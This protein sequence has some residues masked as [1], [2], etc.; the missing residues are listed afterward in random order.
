MIH[1]A[2]IIENCVSLGD[3]VTVEPGAVI[4]VK[5]AIRNL[6]HFTGSVEIGRH[7]KIGANVVVAIGEGITKIGENCIIMN[8]ANIGHDV[9]IGNNVEIGAGVI[10]CGHAVIGDNCKIKTGSIIRN[11]VTIE[12]DTIVGMGSVVTKDLET[13]TYY[14]NP[15]R[16]EDGWIKRKV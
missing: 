16:P 8:L 6:K 13:G 3:N 4:G 12:K 14:G 11:R 2:S 1:F 15:A 5:G 10:V 9:T 7:T